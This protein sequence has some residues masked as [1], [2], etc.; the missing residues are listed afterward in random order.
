[1]LAWGTPM[2]MTR[3]CISVY[4]YIL[5][6]N[7]LNLV[8]YI[9]IY[10]TYWGNHWET[11][12]LRGALCSNKPIYYP[13]YIFQ[14]I[15]VCL[16]MEQDT[17]SCTP[18]LQAF[19]HHVNISCAF[20]GLAMTTLAPSNQ[21]WSARDTMSL[22][23]QSSSYTRRAFSTPRGRRHGHIS[24]S[25]TTAGE[26]RSRKVLPWLPS[27]PWHTKWNGM[28]RPCCH[29]QLPCTKLIMSDH[30]TCDDSSFGIFNW[31]S[32]NQIHTYIYI[33]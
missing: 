8:I 2:D 7:L 33:L 23:R 3:R 28:A 29:P 30:G 9:Y 20:W 31:P 22:K 16:K 21:S 19:H 1:M 24:S 4:I 10:Y 6:K 32:F 5:K 25:P 11:S 14:I 12:G 27:K 15:P 17:S 13:I 26:G 18:W